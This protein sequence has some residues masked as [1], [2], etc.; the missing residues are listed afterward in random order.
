MGKS[1]S[2]QIVEFQCHLKIVMKIK[3]FS[4]EIWDSQQINY[5]FLFSQ[6]PYKYH[7]MDI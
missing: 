7:L 5:N 4:K 2:F 1:Y 6:K 3:V